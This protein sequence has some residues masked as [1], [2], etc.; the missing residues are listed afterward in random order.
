M[1]WLEA[2]RDLQ[3]RDR[4]ERGRRAEPRE[5]KHAVAYDWKWNQ[6][7]TKYRARPR[8]RQDLER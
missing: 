8:P 6:A 4:R 5:A 3:R 7:S 2:K 1:S